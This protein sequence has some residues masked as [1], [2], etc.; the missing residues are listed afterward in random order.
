MRIIINHDL[1]SIKKDDHLIIE[2]MVILLKFI[3]AES[4]EDI[5]NLANKDLEVEVILEIEDGY[6]NL[7]NKGENDER[8]K[9]TIVDTK[10]G[11]GKTKCILQHGTKNTEKRT[12]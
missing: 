10:I 11:I 4:V 9:S 1:E 7:T 2:W 3:E 12:Q 8:T 5:E 6:C